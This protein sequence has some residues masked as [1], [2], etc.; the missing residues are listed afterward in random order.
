MAAA[1]LGLERLPTPL[2]ELLIVSDDAGRLRIVDWAENEERIAILLRRQRDLAGASLVPARGRNRPA[3]ALEAYF[4]GHLAAID[5]MPV[6][7][8]GTPFQQLVWGALRAIPCGRTVSYRELACRIG[9]PAAVRAVGL[10]NGANP[11]S[12][13]VPCHRVIGTDGRLTGYGGGVER[14][15]WLLAHEGAVPAGLQ[16]DLSVGHASLPREHELT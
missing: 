7:A 4:A 9:Q 6:G 13:V 5:G 3:E 11:V 2:G 15:R 1:R 10:A 8:G 14:K 12:I 16:L